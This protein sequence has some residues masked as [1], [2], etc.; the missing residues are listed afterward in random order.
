MGLPFLFVYCKSAKPDGTN[1]NHE[2]VKDSWCWW[3]RTYAP[4][5]RT[6]ER[7]EAEARESRIG[8]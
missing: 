4:G 7:L 1:I 2:L 3:Y 5:D 8:L 6:L